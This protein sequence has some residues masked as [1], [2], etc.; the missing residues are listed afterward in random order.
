MSRFLRVYEL[1]KIK[2][3]LPGSIYNPFV[4]SDSSWWFR[5]GDVNAQLFSGRDPAGFWSERTC[6]LRGGELIAGRP[7]ECGMHHSWGA[8]YPTLFDRFVC[9]T[10][11]DEAN[12]CFS[13]NSH[14]K[15]RKTEMISWWRGLKR[16]DVGSLLICTHLFAPSFAQAIWVGW[17]YRGFYAALTDI[18]FTARCR[19]CHGYTLFL[20]AVKENT[21]MDSGI[22][23]IRWHVYFAMLR[24]RWGVKNQ[25]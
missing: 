15:G 10:M 24:S 16:I 8:T 23:T 21:K 17:I 2:I 3:R 7:A 14:Q 18:N 9:K 25:S 5:I 20:R 11:T 13:L 12:N 22:F 1:P 19:L 6:A 4:T